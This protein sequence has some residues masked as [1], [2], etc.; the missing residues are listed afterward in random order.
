MSARALGSLSVAGLCLAVVAGCGRTRGGDAD[1]AAPLS[2][3]TT[4]PR[5]GASAVGFDPAAVASAP[6]TKSGPKKAP[7][8]SD[9]SS[10]PD[11][12]EPNDAPDPPEG[13]SGPSGPSAPPAP[14][15][16]RDLE[17]IPLPNE[18]GKPAPKPSA[19]K[20]TTL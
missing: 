19:P 15:T 4:I 3:G 8:P 11:P 10:E 17:P 6:R 13:P 18:D 14:K 2:L 7:S 5:A 12:P 20:G 16:P 9:P 1:E